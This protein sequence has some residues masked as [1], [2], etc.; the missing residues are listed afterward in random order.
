MQIKFIDGTEGKS[1]GPAGTTLQVLAECGGVK[2]MVQGF[3][4]EAGRDAKAKSVF[5]D[6]IEAGVAP[7]AKVEPSY[8]KTWKTQIESVKAVEK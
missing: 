2:R 4:D 7:P 6:I 8:G 1:T 3:T 5:A